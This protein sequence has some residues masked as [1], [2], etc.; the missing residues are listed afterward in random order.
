MNGIVWLASPEWLFNDKLLEWIDFAELRVP[1]IQRLPNTDV[2]W[3]ISSKHPARAA[4]LGAICRNRRHRDWRARHEHGSGV[5][6][7]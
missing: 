2:D 1:R 6:E 3:A 7:Q 4:I 5:S